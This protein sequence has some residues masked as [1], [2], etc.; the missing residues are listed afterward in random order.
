MGSTV[1]A[2]YPVMSVNG[3]SLEYR[4]IPGD[5]VK[6]TLVLLHEGLGCVALWRDFP[7]RL[8]A[9]TG[10]SVFAYS[11]AGYGGSDPIE[12][13]RPLEYMSIEAIEILPDVL[14]SAKIQR[15]TLI[16]HSD[17]ASIALVYAGKVK[18]AGLRSVVILAP[19]VFAEQ[20]GVDS[21]AAVEESYID[22]DLRQRLKKYHGAN[23]D[24]AFRGWCDSWL[25]PQFLH[26]TIVPD[27]AG[28]EVPVLQIQGRD[29][30]YGTVEQ[31]RRIETE[32]DVAVETLMLEQCGHA[33]H[34][35]RSDETLAA[36][37]EFCRQPGPAQA[38]ERR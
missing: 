26:W 12:L 38:S 11:R 27:L 35:E 18:D 23:V 20:S 2:A 31:L 17:G 5:P 8:A 4:M 13:P 15:S 28:I 34:L 16:G 36:I 30:E 32:I 10:R 22:G 1:R 14:E 33:P 9:A 24:C 21:I 37:A 6:P 19:H 7:D 29:D 3:I 25:N